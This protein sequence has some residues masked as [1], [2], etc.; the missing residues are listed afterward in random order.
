MYIVIFCSFLALLLT[1]LESSG[2]LKGGM[3]Y[4]FFI[5]TFLGCIHY[6]YGNDYMQYY[7]LFEDVTSVPFDFEGIMDGYYYREPGWVLLCWAFK[8]VGFFTMVAVFNIFQ[9]WLI[10]R[11]I[12][13]EVNAGW[14]TFAMFIYLFNTS[15]YLMSF[16]MMRQFLVAVIFLGL[17][18]LIQ[19]RKWWIPLGV[20]FLCSFIHSSAIVLLPFAFWGY[21]PIENGKLIGIAY[22][23]ILLVLWFGQDL[24]NQ[25]FQFSIENNEQLSKYADTYGN[26]MNEG[27]KLGLGFVINLIPIVLSIS[28]LFKNSTQNNNEHKSIVALALISSLIIPFAN[29]IQLITRLTTYFG[30]YT[31]ASYPLIYDSIHNKLSRCILIVLA[32]ALTMYS[33]FQFFQNEVWIDKYTEFHTVFSQI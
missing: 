18:P 12:R 17:W 27:L 8:P 28:Y 14:Y 25:I 22:A 32:V 29:I 23:F 16:T 5:V 2:T 7:H 31:I 4:G 19:K 26:N 1:Y 21:I 11:T 10:Y 13:R 20:L 33:Y 3:K 24:I 30:V 15:Y 9:N 6:D